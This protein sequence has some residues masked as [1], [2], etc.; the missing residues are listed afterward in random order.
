LPEIDSTGFQQNT[1]LR[2][3]ETLVLA[4]FERNEN[5]INDLGTP[6]LSFLLGGS[7]NRTQ[8]REVTVMLITANIMPEDPF[9]VYASNK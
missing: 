3:G 7:R 2:S 4:G 9:T 6:G 8:K 1:V 5:S